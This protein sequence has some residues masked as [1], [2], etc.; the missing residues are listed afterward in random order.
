MEDGHGAGSGDRREP[1]PRRSTV[2]GASR[3]DDDEENK[4]KLEAMRFPWSSSP[5]VPTSPTTPPSSGSSKSGHRRAFS[6]SL[7]QKLSFLRGNNDEGKEPPKSPRSAKSRKS[8]DDDVPV[9][10]PESPHKPEQTMVIALQAPKTR[11]RK[12]SL[13]KTALLGGR[14]FASEGRERKNS[15]T[16]KSPLGKLSVQHAIQAP[17][18]LVETADA[19][20]ADDEEEVDDDQPTP[21]P[22]TQLSYEYDLSQ[23]SSDSGWSEPAAVTATRLILITEAKAQLHQHPT[24]NSSEDQLGSPVDIKSPIS[25]ASYASTT[26]DDDILTFDRRPTT[27]FPNPSAL[28]LPKPISSTSTSYFPSVSDVSIPRHRS[29][30]SSKRSPLSHTISS[31]SLYSH[32]TPPPHDYTETEYWGWVILFVTWLTFTVGMGSCL[33][34]WSWAWDVGETPYAPPELEDDPTLPI[35]GYYPALGVLVGV[36]AWVWITVAWVGMKYFRHARVEV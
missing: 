26:D 10:S 3:Q 32:P 5:S 21:G 14:R 20:A 24:A 11:K 36:V 30:R 35:V 9:T 23:S 19:P 7:L 27:S 28:T 4:D 31:S 29:T 17:M 8:I 12:G 22:R 6:G 2:S 18:K 33:E 15:F 13:R 16:A 25:N 1:A 34:V